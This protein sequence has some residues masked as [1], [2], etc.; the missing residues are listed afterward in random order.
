MKI[1]V[2]EKGSLEFYREVVCATAQYARLIKKPEAK[3]VDSFKAIKTYVVLCAVMFVL[4]LVMG[5]AWGMDLLT[6]VAIVMIGLALALSILQLTRLNK[7]VESMLN[8][9]HDSIFTVD[10]EGVE[11]EKV[12]SQLV[13]MSW[14]NV[15]FVRSFDESLCFFSKD[16]RGFVLALTKKYE[17]QVLDYIK[18]EG[19]AVRIIK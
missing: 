8:G 19:F 7:V 3:L 12:G 15:A 11:L 16:V 14:N 17:Q 18:E 5:I 2:K 9:P 10:E 1:E 6:I 4:L 13:R